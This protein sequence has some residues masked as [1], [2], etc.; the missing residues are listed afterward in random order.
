MQSLFLD[1]FN[2]LS[3]SHPSWDLFVLLFL[4]IGT[5]IY[6]FS[7]GRGRIIMIMVAVYMA[8]VAVNTLPVIPQI[9]AVVQLSNGFVLRVGT[10]LGLFAILFF[11]LTRSALNHALDTN[12]PLGRWWHVLLLSF[13]QVG[14][15]ISVV[16]SFF[17]PAW[18]D[19]MSLFIRV[20]F[21]SPWGKFSWVVA[22]IFGLLI[23]GLSI[24]KSSSRYD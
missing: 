7:L 1:F 8:V 22:P 20:V 11:M 14:M 13:V 24:E 5:L 10:F 21:A 17:P 6:G 4:L 16:M 9:G 2:S 23:V 18:L 19:K 12:S 3:W 15:L